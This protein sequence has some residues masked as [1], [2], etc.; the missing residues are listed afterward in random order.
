MNIHCWWMEWGRLMERPH[1][2]VHTIFRDRIW[3]CSSSKWRG[4]GY[5]P[6]E[7]YNSWID[8]GK[9]YEHFIGND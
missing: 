8:A 5:T 7:A 6:E 2:T 1:I 9:Q 4:Y 3:M